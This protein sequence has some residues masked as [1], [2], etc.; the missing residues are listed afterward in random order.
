LEGASRNLVNRNGGSGLGQYLYVEGRTPDNPRPLSDVSIKIKEQ[1][2]LVVSLLVSGRAPGCRSLEY[3]IRMYHSQ[4]SID[5]FVHMDKEDVFDPEAVHFAW[6]F[7]IP[8]GKMRIDAGWGYFRPEEEQ[9]PGSC[10]NYFTFQRWLDISNPNTGVTWTS[11]DAPLIEIGD[12]TTDATAFGWIKNLAG[13]QTFYSYLMNNYWETNYKA[14]QGGRASFSYSLLPYSG[15]FDPIKAD[16]FGRERCQPLV[17]LP[18]REESPPPVSHL[19]ILSRD[20][21]LTSLKPSMD[22]RAVLLRLFNPS[23][24]ETS[25]DIEWMGK[26]PE[27]IF[28]SSPFEDKKGEISPPLALPPFHILTLRIEK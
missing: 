19:K 10:K 11:P 26:K 4:D 2:P 24:R 5:V 3:E 16:R 18:V 25:A 17:P 15:P 22:G 6:P 21:V 23:N 13:Q 14:S 12:I 27:R 1:G 9:L 28:L 7:S 20:V 8:G